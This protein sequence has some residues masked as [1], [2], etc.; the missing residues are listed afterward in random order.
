MCT[1]APGPHGSLLL[2]NLDEYKRAPHEALRKWSREHG[3]VVRF[4]IGPLQFY[5]LN[6]NELIKQVLVDRVANYIKGRT[7]ERMQP[8]LG[9]GVIRINGA[10]WL[11]RRRLMQPAFHREKIAAFA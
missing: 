9:E 10:P 3:P 6:D 1:V 7:G 8:L 2:G 11:R 4:R 5:L